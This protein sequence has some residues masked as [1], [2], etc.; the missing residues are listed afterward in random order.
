MRAKEWLKAAE[1]NGWR[2]KSSRS[3]VLVL[4]CCRQGCPG[5]VTA[6]LDNLGHVPEPCT[7]DHVGQ[8]SARTFE[9]Y[10]ALVGQLVRRR[11][12]LGISQEDLNAAA[13]LTDGHINKLE[14]L[15]RV[16]QMP[17]LQ[18]WA[19]TLGLSLGL[20]PA[21]LPEAT[22]RTIARRAAPLPNRPTPKALTS[23]E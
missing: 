20:N 8:Y 2:V 13:G 18:L 1:A 21:A 16:A 7:L 11:R 3:L 19:E 6:P 14:A 5:T 12:Q 22:M 4:K 15:H 23:D 10:R 9:T 17:T